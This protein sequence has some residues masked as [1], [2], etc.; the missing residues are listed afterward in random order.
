MASDIQQIEVLLDGMYAMVSGPAGP[1]DWSRQYDV[2]HPLCR[3]I[4]TGCDEQ[5]HAWFKM[6]DPEQYR[7]DADTIFA[8]QAFYEVETRREIRIFG[9]MAHVWSAYEAR[10]D[11]SDP[12]PERRGINSIQLY[13][14]SALGWRVISMIWDN[15]RPGLP[16]ED[17]FPETP[18]A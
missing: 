18:A 13:R 1:R 14:D 11:L 6:F 17:G 16:L 4:R 3:Q 2:F 8:R 7:T 10:T 5:G 15:E 12:Q 9:N